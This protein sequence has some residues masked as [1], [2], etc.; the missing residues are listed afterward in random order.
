MTNLVPRGSF[1]Q[2]LFDFRRDFDQIFN[3]ML[4][5]APLGY[6]RAAGSSLIMAPPVETFIDK[7]GKSFH[8]RIS[9]P[10]VDP[11]EVQIHAQGNSL[12]ISGERKID[13]VTKE[14]DFHHR[15]IWYGAFERTLPLPDGVD[16]NKL[17]AEYTNGVLELTA[18]I[19][20]SALPRRIE[21]RSAPKSKQMTAA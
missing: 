17:E 8:C 15:E 9:L 2:D 3:R 16:A 7:D 14:A 20:A 6:E 12:T 4:T 21:I 1:F 18:P 10:G 5:G 13:N 11:K 19:A